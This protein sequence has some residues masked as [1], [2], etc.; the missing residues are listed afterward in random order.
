MYDHGTLF[1]GMARLQ[2][3]NV[4]PTWDTCEYSELKTDHSILPK[5][6]WWVIAPT[7]GEIVRVR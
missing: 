1:W 5:F 2:K 3:N 7:T 6:P 4:C